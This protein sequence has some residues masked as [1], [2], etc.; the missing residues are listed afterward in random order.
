M[1]AELSYNKVTAFLLKL[2]DALEGINVRIDRRFVLG[3]KIYFFISI[4]LSLSINS[5]VMMKYTLKE[6]GGIFSIQLIVQNVMYFIV[7]FFTDINLNTGLI[8]HQFDQS[9]MKQFNRYRLHTIC[10]TLILFTSGSLFEI[11]YFMINGPR[12]FLVVFGFTGNELSGPYTEYLLLVNVV[13]NIFNLTFTLLIFIMRYLTL[14]H[15]I[16]LLGRQNLAFL[17][18]LLTEWQLV[19]YDED[20]YIRIGEKYKFYIQSVERIN[21]GFGKVPFWIFVTIYAEITS[22]GAVFVVSGRNTGALTL[23]GTHL[24]ALVMIIIFVL[25]LMYL[26]KLGHDA[27]ERFH[28]LAVDLVSANLCQ[29]KTRVSTC[30]SLA[31]ILRSI[32]LKKMKAGDIY[33]MEYSLLISLIGSAIPMT[34]M[35]VSLIKEYKT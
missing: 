2:F 35:V 8:T 21:S 33:D 10:V 26:C 15:A 14:V 17:E 23:S 16:S 19:D 22:L 28:Q 34:V 9:H 18:S 25:R 31:N 27:M 3:V 20:L 29:I 30:R 6:N 7:I 32:S 12:T 4:V 24:I 13:T 5:Y 1:I 11:A